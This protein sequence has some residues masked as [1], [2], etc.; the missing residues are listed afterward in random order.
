MNIIAM[1]DTNELINPWKNIKILSANVNSPNLS[2]SGPKLEEKSVAITQLGADLILLQ[3]VRA[4]DKKHIIE[5]TFQCTK[6][7][8][9]TVHTNSSMDRR[10]ISTLINT[11]CNISISE[12]IDSE[13]ENYSILKLS[14]L[15]KEIVI[16]NCYGPTQTE[17]PSFFEDL[18]NTLN[19]FY[20]LPV[21]I[22]GDLNAITNSQK[23]DPILNVVNPDIIG[24]IHVPNPRNSKTLEKWHNDGDYYDIFRTLNPS[25]IEYSYIGFR[26][27]VRANDHTPQPRNH[28]DIQSQRSRIDLVLGN[29][30]ALNLVEKIEYKISSKLFDHKFQLIS[31][32]APKKGPPKTNMNQ[33][34]EIGT[35]EL[36]HLTLLNTISDYSTNNAMPV[37]TLQNLRKVAK[38]IS[39]CVAENKKVNDKLY[40][41]LLN[42]VIKKYW[43]L[44][45]TIPPIET[46]FEGNFSIDPSLF[47]QTLLNNINVEI[48][49]FQANF[50]KAKNMKKDK[51]YKSLN[52]ILK[53]PGFDINE[54]LEIEEKIADYEQ[55]QINLKCKNSKNWS[56]LNQ[57]KGS[58]AFCA[59]AKNAKNETSFDVLKNCE[60]IPPSDFKSEE[61]KNALANKFYQHIFRDVD[62]EINITIQEF[63][64]EEI[65]NSDYVQNKKLSPEE[66]ELLDTPINIREIKEVVMNCNSNSAPGHDNFT[67]NFIK[68]YFE[69]LKFPMLKAFNYFIEEGKVTHNFAIS[70]IKL[71]PK[72]E[73][74]ENIKSWRPISLLSVFYKVFSGCIADRLKTVLD[75]ICSPSQ[76]GYSATKNINEVSVSVNNMIKAANL[77]NIQMS[78]ISIDFKKAFDSLSH[79]YIKH[80][81]SFFNFGPYFLKLVDA[82]LKGKRA[83]ISNLKNSSEM[84]DISSGVAQGDKPSG[85]LFNIALEPLLTL[86]EKCP[87]IEDVT[88]P[89]PPGHDGPEQL[90]GQRLSTYADDCNPMVKSTENNI[91]R[92]KE[93]LLSFSR[94]SALHANIDKTSIC[95][96]N[97]TI[98]FEEFIT[99][100]GFRIEKEFKLLGIHYDHKGEH[101]DEKNTKKIYDKIK[102]IINFWTNCYLTIPGKITILKTFVYSQISYF[103]PSIIYTNQFY[104]DVESLIVKFI[105]KSINAGPD[106]CFNSIKSGGLGL[107]KVED[108]VNSIKVSFF[109]RHFNSNDQ[110]ANAIKN[111]SIPGNDL[112]FNDLTH[113]D[114]YYPCSAELVRSYNTFKESFFNHPENVK[115]NFLLYNTNIKDR[116]QVLTTDTFDELNLSVDEKILVHNLKIGNLINTNTGIALT[117]RQFNENCNID[118]PPATYSKMIRSSYNLRKKYTPSEVKPPSLS[119]YMKSKKKL[120]KIFRQYLKPE[121]KLSLILKFKP[122]KTRQSKMNYIGDPVRESSLY[123][124][125]SHSKLPNEIRNFLYKLSQ[126]SNKLNVHMN[127]IKPLVSPLCHSCRAVGILPEPIENMVHIYLE[128]PS[129][130]SVLRHI[131]INVKPE[132]T[133]DIKKFFINDSE[134][135]TTSIERIV[136]GVLI[137]SITLHRNTSNDKLNLT[138]NTFKKRIKELAWIDNH[139]Q[140]RAN[141]IFNPYYI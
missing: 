5:K 43:D 102:N 25:K 54:V 2:N 136:L 56:T 89:G 31:L 41:F 126:N 61:E 30:N 15:G 48:A 95:P 12:F 87:L 107:F 60:T 91:I 90:L 4:S 127:K 73:C 98:E 117:R 58:K 45:V 42:A 99:S 121:K 116:G 128:C 17:T 64:G 22:I 84:I 137:Y 3:D 101:I 82:C 78:I 13:D 72:K 108:Y 19:R 138:V 14:R 32:K 24:T 44:N 37:Q 47:L 111:A 86:I 69:F 34:Q 100:Q 123:K 28:F 51:L 53:M 10:G 68:I 66:K 27:R 83:Y 113:L 9:Y 55:E 139:F 105:G 80:A 112:I 18:K 119:F 103:A 106:K 29:S 110:W 67:Y 140:H 109:K 122:T 74:L 8:N 63:L 38:D 115:E 59:I 77:N 118:L 23:P 46:L 93:I 125:W 70:K 62:N 134:N 35:K 36:V 6:G 88:I 7:G 76:K 130:E 26:G 52:E 16:C 131:N 50:C 94:V 79:A 114:Q 135:N 20:N 65:T 129:T 141:M 57:E 120:S 49:G 92:I 39:I 104:S 33:I 96:I 71:I 40:P 11:K 124:V 85:P 75:R 1:C 97:S 133:L 132:F 81:L 21:F